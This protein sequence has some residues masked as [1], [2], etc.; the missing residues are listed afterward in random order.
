MT[1]CKNFPGADVLN[2]QI[3]SCRSCHDFKCAF[4]SAGKQM[5]SLVETGIAFFKILHYPA[6]FTA[7]PSDGDGIPLFVLF[8]GPIG[9]IRLPADA[10]ISVLKIIRR[11]DPAIGEKVCCA[12]WSDRTVPLVFVIKNPNGFDWRIIVRFTVVKRRF[13]VV[14]IIGPCADRIRGDEI[15]VIGGYVG[16]FLVFLIRIACAP[17]NEGQRFPAAGIQIRVCNSNMACS[18]VLSK[19]GFPPYQSARIEIAAAEDN[20]VVI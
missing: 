17:C 11:A 7:D 16:D 9:K 8:I 12:D 2:E 1:L 15:I 4:M 18:A 13:S 19:A 6:N 10:E 20:A 3:S 14:R 5:Q